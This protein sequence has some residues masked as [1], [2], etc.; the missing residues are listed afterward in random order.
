MK[1]TPYDQYWNE[2]KNWK[3]RLVYVCREDPRIIVPKKPAWMGRTLN[4]AHPKSYLVLFLTI[5][6]LTIPFLLHQWIGEPTWLIVF[7]AIVVGIVVFYYNAK[8]YQR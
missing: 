1:S 8:L 2:P 4:F 3:W 5:L 6:A 7:L